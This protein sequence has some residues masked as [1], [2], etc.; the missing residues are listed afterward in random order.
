M[1]L[2]M[3]NALRLL[4]AATM[5]SLLMVA[6]HS[7]DA[8]AR[9]EQRLPQAPVLDVTVTPEG[10]VIPGPNPRPGGPV[11]FRVTADGAHGYW[12]S[13]YRL[14]GD[15]T[16]DQFAEWMALSGSDD[17]EISLPALRNLYD[18]VEYSGGAKVYPS[19]PIELTQDLKPGIYYFGSQAIPGPQVDV[20]PQATTDDAPGAPASTDGPTA[21]RQA[22]DA[23]VDDPPS[24]FGYLEVTDERAP[25]RP[26][27]IDS[28]IYMGNAGDRDFLVSPGSMPADGNILVR[29]DSSQP[30][31]AVFVELRPGA[32]DR[33]IREYYEAQA[34]G[35]PLPERPFLDS[36]GG[37]LALAPDNQL[38]LGI[39]LPP[40]RY[41]I[42]SFL[43]DPDTGLDGAAT[44][45]HRVVRL[46]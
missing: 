7:T 44:G 6:L 34:E 19:S 24:V 21:Q 42:M 14:R 27:R 22:V 13:A 16:I 46:R 40:G 32:T 10:F 33:D 23:L 2:R 35:R 15:T 3:L 30:Q 31:E 8:A 5:L 4:A 25:A 38:I 43:R 1:A 12:W 11:T 20:A 18:N 9:G 37:M 45:M 36:I 41:A 29:N 39:D 26:P 17:P 28:A